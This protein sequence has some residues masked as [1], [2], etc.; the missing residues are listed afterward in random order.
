[1]ITVWPLRATS[2]GASLIGGD[3]NHNMCIRS[4]SPH[5]VHWISWVSRQAFEHRAIWNPSICRIEMHLISQ[6]DQIVHIAGEIINFNKNESILTEV[7]YKYSLLG[8]EKLASSAGFAVEAL[9]TDDK[10]FF[11]VQLLKVRS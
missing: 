8:F 9:W 7:S 11:S 4:I 3:L 10:H 2:L 5:Y 6:T 1:M